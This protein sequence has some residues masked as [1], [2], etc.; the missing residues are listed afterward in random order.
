MLGFELKVNLSNSCMFRVNSL[1]R[2]FE[3]S[4]QLLVVQDFKLAPQFPHSASSMS[5]HSCQFL[6]HQQSPLL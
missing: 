2:S 6:C 4:L 5:P 1:P 3:E